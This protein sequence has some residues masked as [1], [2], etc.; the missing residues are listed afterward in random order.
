MKYI[1]ENAKPFY[2]K[3]DSRGCLLIHGFTGCPAE[4]RLLGEHLKDLGY[5]VRGLQLKGHGTSIED[6]EKSDWRKWLDSAEEELRQ[7]MTNCDEI[8]IIGL[9]M[10]GIIS[11]ILSSKYDVKGI[12]SLSSPIKITNKKAYYSPIMKYFKKYTPKEV[13]TNTKYVE[14]YCISYDKTPVSKVPDLLALIRKAKRNLKKIY[15]PI[16]IIQSKDDNTV[17]YESAE[18]IFKKIRSKFKKLIYLKESGHVI[19]LGKER[20]KVFKEIDAF[21]EQV[22]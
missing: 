15:S 11:L 13:S 19:T 17:K 5:T 7:L 10:G 14:E 9:S 6:M 21:L 1:H 22:F 3:G 20:E 12:V 18:I 16:L 4:M 2:F 8:V